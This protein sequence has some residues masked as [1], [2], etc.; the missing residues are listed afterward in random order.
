MHRFGE[1]AHRL[2]A[3]V[4]IDRSPGRGR[5]ISHHLTP[6]GEAILVAE[7]RT[8]RHVPTESFAERSDCDRAKPLELLTR[9]GTSGQLPEM[10]EPA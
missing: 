2:I 9:L 10:P 3:Q 7:R 6:K 1:I 5:R 4:L 8:A